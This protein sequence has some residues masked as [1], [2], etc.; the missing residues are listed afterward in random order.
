MT[1]ETSSTKYLHGNIWMGVWLNHWRLAQPSWHPGL[2]ITVP[3]KL[4]AL[5]NPNICTVITAF[6]SPLGYTLKY[7]IFGEQ[8]LTGKRGF[9]LKILTCKM[10]SLDLWSSG[11]WG[12]A[13]TWAGRTVSMFWSLSVPHP[14]ERGVRLSDV[15]VWVTAVSCSRLPM[16]CRIGG[17]HSGEW[18]LV[19]PKVLWNLHKA[20]LSHRVMGEM[21]LDQPPLL[22]LT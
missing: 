2:T 14:T 8:T 19:W 1:D 5:K 17:L 4:F 10:P 22:T 20:S 21:G 13:Q 11:A 7:I 16:S 6:C 12:L 3:V 15:N 18:F 9:L